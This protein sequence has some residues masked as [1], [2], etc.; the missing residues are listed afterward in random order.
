MVASNTISTIDQP[1]NWFKFS[2]SLDQ[3]LQQLYSGKALKLIDGSTLLVRWMTFNDIPAVL[4]LERAIFPSPWVFEAFTYELTNLEYNISLVGLIDNR[5][6]AYAVSYL[7]VDEAHIS[8]I[9]VS[10]AYRKL[11]IGETLLLISLQ[12]GQRND[13]KVAHLE[14]RKTNE[15]A[16]SLYKKYGFKITGLR[17]NYYEEENEDALLMS[18]NLESEMKHGLV[19]KK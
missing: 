11:K 10:P 14:V 3:L 4:D 5:I 13:C 16:I 9:A 15:A 12:I 8:N 2:D 1:T 7:V 19:Q 6:V 18:L 17:K